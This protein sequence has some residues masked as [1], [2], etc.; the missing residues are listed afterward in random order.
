MRTYFVEKF[1]EGDKDAQLEAMREVGF[2]FVPLRDAE[3]LY[4]ASIAKMG[5]AIKAKQHNNLPLAVYCWDYYSWSH[6]KVNMSGDWN[7]YA[8][9]L[10]MA[11]IIFVPSNGQKLR[12]KELLDLESVVVHTGVPTYEMETSDGN[13]IL[14]PV[15]YY[16]ETNRTWAEEA[17]Q[18]LGI[19]IIHSEHGY[20]QE[21]FRKLVANCTFL[22]CAYKEASTGGLS[23]MEG[24]YLGKTSLVSDS[25]YMGARDYLGDLG[26]YFDFRDFKDLKREMAKMWKTRPNI[27]RFTAR[28][29]MKSYS[30]QE[31]AYKLHHSCKQLLRKCSGSFSMAALLS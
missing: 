31:M 11:D 21:E 3:I 18:E 12:L 10:R 13:Y 19:P 8:D 20:S 16:P 6:G 26:H 15:R 24:L 23:L 22:T 7:R 9:F 30:Y 29:H 2:E 28:N 27:D 1:S 5:E 4:C 14:D 25:P 17:A